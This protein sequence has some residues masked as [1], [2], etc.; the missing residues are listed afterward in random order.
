MADLLRASGFEVKVLDS[1]LFDPSRKSIKAIFRPKD[2]QLVEAILMA[3]KPML[4]ANVGVQE[5][6][7]R[8]GDEIVILIMGEPVFTPEGIK[9]FE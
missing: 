9:V 8:P 3:F 5:V 4:H 2:W 6:P 1:Q 7:G